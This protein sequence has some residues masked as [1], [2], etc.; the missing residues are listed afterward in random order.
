MEAIEAT[1]PLR[2]DQKLVSV[3][4]I[5]LLYGALYSLVLLRL[6]NKLKLLPQN[7]EKWICMRK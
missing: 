1:K 5:T 2:N 6:K 7:A 3:I 4:K